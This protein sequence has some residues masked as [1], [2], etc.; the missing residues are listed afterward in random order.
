MKLLIVDDEPLARVRL[1]RLCERTDDLHVVAEAESGV[2]AIK[3]AQ[4]FSPDV[5]LLDVELPDM[6]GF[7]VLRAVRTDPAPLGIMVTAHAEH[8]VTAY[9]AGAFDYLLK[10][11]RDERFFR[12]I[13]RA[14]QRC[15]G[16]LW[17]EPL[18]P[19]VQRLGVL[20][21]G[22]RRPG[23]LV[24]EREHRLYPLDPDK[25]DYV[26]SAGNYVKFCVGRT[27]YISR[28]SVKRLALALAD[29][30]FVRIERSLLVNVRAILYVE[31]TG[32]GAFAFTLSTGACL[33]SSPTFRDAI[34]RVLPLAQTSNRMLHH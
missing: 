12:C 5:L 28:D 20:S 31:P 22:F 25:I 8:A 14:R 23:L 29:R 3:A 15:G 13:D 16:P 17:S 10:P 2:A 24:G 6:T 32:R 1:A 33:Y 7:D 26:E 30:G 34:L 9:D 4:K 19:P 21:A 11:F 18:S 27:E